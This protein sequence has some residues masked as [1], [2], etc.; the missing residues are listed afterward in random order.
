M[1]ADLRL[2]AATFPTPLGSFTV[3]ASEDGVVATSSG[4]PERAAQEVGAALRTVVVPAGRRLAG[5]GRELDRYFAGR[6]RRFV[7]PVDLRLATTP[8]GRSILEVVRG[9]PYG[10]LWTY[11]D[12]AGLAG[13]PGAARAA[14]SWLRRSPIELFVPCHRV[15]PSGPGFGSY[16]GDGD[17]RAFLLRLEGAA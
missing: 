11:G 15:V 3:I 2:V 6:L 12:V 9:I 1:A 17:R 14:G 5:A 16:G 10:E 8:F 4:D 7:T 13:R